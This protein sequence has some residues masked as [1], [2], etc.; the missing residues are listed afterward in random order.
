[1]HL[2]AAVQVSLGGCETGTKAGRCQKSRINYA[3]KDWVQEV[4][5][6]LEAGSQ[7]ALKSFPGHYMR[8]V[9]ACAI[10]NFSFLL[11]CIKFVK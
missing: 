7:V 3:I 4:G 10:Q 9:V 5:I 11:H 1:M 2:A 8:D 6:K